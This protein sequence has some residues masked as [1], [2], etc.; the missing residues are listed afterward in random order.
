MEAP[1]EWMEE[2]TTNARIQPDRL[3]NIWHTR[4]GL[5][6]A[7]HRGAGDGFET[8]ELGGHGLRDLPARGG[9]DRAESAGTA[10][11]R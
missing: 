9:G 6:S 5:A 1:Q 7:A 10:R 3:S 2:Q 8:D 4:D 11:V